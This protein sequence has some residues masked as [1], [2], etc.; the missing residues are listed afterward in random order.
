MPPIRSGRFSLFDTSRSSWSQSSCSRQHA[1]ACSRGCTSRR[2]AGHGTPPRPWRSSL[3]LRS[4][5]ASCVCAVRRL[6]PA[7]SPAS[8]HALSSLRPVQPHAD[9]RRH[10]PLALR[11]RGDSHGHFARALPPTHRV[12]R[13]MYRGRGPADFHYL[14][15][16]ADRVRGRPPRAHVGARTTRREAAGPARAPPRGPRPRRHVDVPRRLLCAAA[17]SSPPSAL[18]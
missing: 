5:K 13:A 17:S 6:R 16:C 7:S 4:W 15:R 14:R 11:P 10:P 9:D 1:P 3:S 12:Q 2:T 8:S 18:H